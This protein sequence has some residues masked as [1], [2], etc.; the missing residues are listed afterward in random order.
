MGSEGGG[1]EEG[2]A[3]EREE[4]QRKERRSIKSRAERKLEKDSL[5]NK[6]K[7]RRSVMQRNEHSF[8]MIHMY[9]YTSERMSRCTDEVKLILSE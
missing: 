7:R 5:S 9:V 6:G 4:K 3:K 8:H 1:Q 2:E